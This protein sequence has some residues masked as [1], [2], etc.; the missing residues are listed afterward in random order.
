MRSAGLAKRL[1]RKL[2]PR[3]GVRPVTVASVRSV[4]RAA[5][6]P[7][8]LVPPAP[9]QGTPATTGA[10]SA[11]SVVPR[12]PGLSEFAANWLFG[13]GAFSSMPVADLPAAPTHEPVAPMDEPLAPTNEPVAPTAAVLAPRREP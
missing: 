12:P 11:A 2:S 8:R 3:I 9:V 1:N 6:T 7:L 4:E 13:E 10:A 5:Q